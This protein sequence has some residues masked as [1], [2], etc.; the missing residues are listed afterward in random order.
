MKHAPKRMRPLTA[1][2]IIAVGILGGIMW[3]YL[4]QKQGPPSFDHGQA[5][6]GEIIAVT[7]EVELPVGI[8]GVAS[9]RVPE[10]PIVIYGITENDFQNALRAAQA[11]R[12]K[13]ATS[14]AVMNKI[15]L[16]R[17]PDIQ[18]QVDAIIATRAS[19]EKESSMGSI[20]ANIQ[21]PGKSITISLV[22]MKETDSL[23]LR[24]VASRAR[25][26]IAKCSRP[27]RIRT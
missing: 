24:G 9:P 22:N 14:A 26:A 4:Q 25:S 2:G 19:L 11:V 7:P 20:R 27:V 10:V 21:N 18:K 12:D 15:M 1:I 5:A 17:N 6:E 16:K 13:F 3:Q 23:R 8:P